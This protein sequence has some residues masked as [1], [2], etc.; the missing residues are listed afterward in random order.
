MDNLV[1]FLFFRGANE[2]VYSPLKVME[3]LER[4]APNIKK[5]IIPGAG[6]DLF[7]VKKETVNSWILK[8]LLGSR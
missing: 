5:G 6:H 8:F 2:K 1:P 3:R 7:V 4:V